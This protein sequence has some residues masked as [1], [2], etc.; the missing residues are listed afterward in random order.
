M[1]MSLPLAE[2]ERVEKRFKKLTMQVRV[3]EERCARLGLQTNE[4]VRRA[5][6][7][8]L[9]ETCG[10]LYRDHPTIPNLA[11]TVLCEGSLVHL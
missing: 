10:L 5:S 1:L 4:D 3:L 2:W 8:T 6:G 11:F 7:N 9:C